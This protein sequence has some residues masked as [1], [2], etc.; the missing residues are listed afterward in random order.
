M[1]RKIRRHLILLKHY[2]QHTSYSCGI[3]CIRML[4]ERF[5]KDYLE[6]YLIDLGNCK[7]GMDELDIRLTLE[8]IGFSCKIYN[9]MSL[10]DLVYKLNKNV[11]LMVGFQDHW[12]IVVGYDKKYILIVDSNYDRIKRINKKRF[13]KLLKTD[14]S[15]ILEIE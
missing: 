8:K 5:G 15:N 4:L 10:N 6:K 13:L 14:D 7:K 12:Q 1:K 9:F 3:A 11:P 2:K